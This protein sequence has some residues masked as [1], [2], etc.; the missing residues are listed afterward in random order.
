ML[1]V[2]KVVG[3]TPCTRVWLCT[4]ARMCRN[5]RVGNVH[6]EGGLMYRG[7]RYRYICVHARV[8]GC[9]HIRVGHAHVWEGTHARDACTCACLY[10]RRPATHTGAQVGGMGTDAQQSSSSWTASPS[11][12]PS[13]IQEPGLLRQCAGHGGGGE[14][15]WQ[16][17]QAVW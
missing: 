14:V 13:P 10:G 8:C 5:T 2:S 15:W 3:H 11:Q 6:V 1:L 17:V 4:S 16:E 12:A 9:L 7:R